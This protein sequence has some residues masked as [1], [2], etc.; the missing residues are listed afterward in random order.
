MLRGMFMNQYPRLSRFLGLTFFAPE[1]R[2]FY[3]QLVVDTMQHRTVHGI[4]RPDMIQLL[5]DAK[6]G[7][8]ANGDEKGA[9]DVM[10]F[11]TVRES[12]DSTTGGRA[13]RTWT[14]DDFTAQSF[15]F[16]LAGFETSATLMCVAVHELMENPEVQQR[17]MA[18]VDAVRD[19]LKAD[20][21]VAGDA[22]GGLTYERLQRMEYL[23]M[24]V[25]EAL[26]KWPPVAATDRQCTRRFVIDDV[27]TV[28]GGPL[29]I[30]AGESILIPILGLHRDPKYYAD[31]GKFDPE[32]FSE[33][34]RHKIDAQTYLPFGAGPRNCIAS[35]FALMQVKAFLFQMLS[36]F[37]FEV[38]ENSCIPLRL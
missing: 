19:E 7:S 23:D 25:S 1:H 30:E 28:G 14:D 37:T 31:P 36:V 15:L 22:G 34:N 8:L 16:F 2:E 38:A 26:R 33:Q 18:E 9:D 5:M 24:V 10:G 4:V 20:A 35:R 17:L 6:R 3:R 12:S 21:S 29:V 27:H 11:A 13:K 32:R